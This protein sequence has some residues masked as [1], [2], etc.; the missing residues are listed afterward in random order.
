[1]L[2]RKIVSFG[3]NL[4]VLVTA[5]WLLPADVVFAQKFQPDKKVVYKTVGDVELE[6]HIFEPANHQASDN[7]PA[8]VFFFGGGWSGGTPKQFYEQSRFLAE[9]GMV[10]ISADYRVK[11]RQKTTPF[12]CVEDGKSA[13]RWLRSHAKELGINPDQIVAGGGSAKAK[14][15][16]SVRCPTR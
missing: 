5:A 6:L 15:T 11:S 13:V 2:R 8:I 3:L 7:A 14:A 12:E 16:Q 1:M 4:L 9:K 10:S